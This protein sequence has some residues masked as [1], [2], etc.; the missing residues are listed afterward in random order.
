MGLGL[1]PGGG[2]SDTPGS[3]TSEVLEKPVAIGSGAACLC[4]AETVGP[5]PGRPET[6]PPSCFPGSLVVS[7]EPGCR[8]S[9]WTPLSGSCEEPKFSKELILC[10]MEEEEACKCGPDNSLETGAG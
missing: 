1:W 9:L 7:P 6:R 4:L 5:R 2:D 10:L 3:L 8:L